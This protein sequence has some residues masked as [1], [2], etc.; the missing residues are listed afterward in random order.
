MIRFVRTNKIASERSIILKWMFKWMHYSFLFW[1]YVLCPP[2]FCV[3]ICCSSASSI[4]SCC[5][6]RSKNVTVMLYKLAIGWMLLCAGPSGKRKIGKCIRAEREQ[7]ERASHARTLR[8]HTTHTQ[9]GR[10]QFTVSIHRRWLV[11]VRFLAF[12]D[13]K[14][15]LIK[16]EWMLYVG[17]LADISLQ[18]YMILEVR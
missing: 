11:D 1:S 10:G 13:G 12:W 16:M 14:I 15:I 2:H 7:R 17:V 3:R 18:L 6:T 5:N 8:T 4:E 9:M